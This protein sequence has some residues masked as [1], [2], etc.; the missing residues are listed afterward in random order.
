MISL[1][2]HFSIEWPILFAAFFTL[3][4][5]GKKGI[6]LSLASSA[7]LQAFAYILSPLEIPV[8]T[9]PMCTF[10]FRFYSWPNYLMLLECYWHYHKKAHFYCH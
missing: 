9:P 7:P 1:A 8:A 5:Q 4:R 2:L 10:Y 3:Q 6:C